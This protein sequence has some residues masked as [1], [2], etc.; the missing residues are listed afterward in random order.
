MT[1][2]LAGVTWRRAAIT[3][4]VST[5]VVA[6]LKLMGFTN[7][8]L[9][10]LVSGLVVG[11]TIMFAVTAAGN[12]TL[13]WIPRPVAQL[14]AV[15]LA[16]VVGTVFVVLVK[17]RS[18]ADTFAEWE[19]ISRFSVT[20]TLGVVFG[21][22][23]TLFLIFRERDARVKA[24]VLKA[25][26]ERSSLARRVAEAQL[27][28]M[29]AQ[30]EPHFLFN[31][32]AN[33]RYLVENEPA[34]ALRM[35]DHLIEYLKAA[36]PQMRESASTLGKEIELVRA[37]LN[38]QQIRMGER[39]SFDFRVP[40]ALLAR[41]FPP[42]MAITL[43]ENAIRHGVEQCCDCV[44]VTVKA[45]V[46]AGRLRL[47]VADTG[48]GM[49]AETGR[50]IGL[51]NLRTRLAEMFGDAGRLVIEDNLPKGVRASIEIPDPGEAR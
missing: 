19:G 38:I 13:R 48:D 29:Q 33:V 1:G 30:V 9:D 44:D 49:K 25:E 26:A 22:L 15:A 20:A 43:V 39:L 32:L 4:V 5:V 36:L 28:L 17:G 47:T 24:T 42:A 10:L 45:E 46:D 18:L 2:I 12:L 31:T 11:F 14:I 37:Y 34:S 40:D 6:L 50:G 21:G 7:T 27:A 51:I 16:S 35:L 41:A 8:F 3:F 23:V